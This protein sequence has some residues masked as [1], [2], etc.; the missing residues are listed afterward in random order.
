MPSPAKFAA[1]LTVALIV[2]PA[3]AQSVA[4]P[5]EVEAAKGPSG[6]AGAG[7]AAGY[8]AVGLAGVAASQ[9]AGFTALHQGLP[10]GSVAEVTALDSGRTILVLVKGDVSDGRVI[11]LSPPAARA[12][13]VVAGAPVRVR[14]FHAEPADL[15]ALNAGQAAPARLD[16]PEALLRGLRRQLPAPARAASA[17]VAARRAPSTPPAPAPH[18]PTAPIAAAVAREPASAPT[19][20]TVAASA[21]ARAAP[22]RRA[23]GKSLIVQVAALGNAGRAQALARSLGGHVENAGGVWRVRLGPFTDFAAAQRARDD[24][25]RRGYGDATIR[26]AD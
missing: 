4:P 20:R 14:A 18:I 5:I 21:P 9:A 15:A 8:D 10:I 13:G 26:I 24:A 2:T 7:T 12:L 25:V 17:P 6:T 23:P 22:S 11:D 16:A 19:P 3:S 1:A